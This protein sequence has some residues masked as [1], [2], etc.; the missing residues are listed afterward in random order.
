MTC[1]CLVD[2][3]FRLGE[4]IGGSRKK[5]SLLRSYK[6][7][8]RRV[9]YSL[10]SDLSRASRATPTTDIISLYQSWNRLGSVGAGLEDQKEQLRFESRRR[11]TCSWKGCQWHFNEV[12]NQ[13]KACSGCSKAVRVVFIGYIVPSDAQ[14]A[15]ILRK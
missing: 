10:L 3:Y 4:R 2:S 13:L 9:W 6:P 12:P 15:E 1:V 11:V 14:P 5:K 7:G 8:L